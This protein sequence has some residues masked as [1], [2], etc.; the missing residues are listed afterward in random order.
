MT[1]EHT[2]TPTVIAI[3]GPAASGKSTAGYM[4]ARELGFLYL[5]TGSMYRAATLAALIAGIDPGNEAA[6]SA[7]SRDLDLQI[8]PASGAADGRQYTVLLDGDDVTWELRSPDVDAH[9]SV[10]SSFPRVREEMVRRQREIAR[11]GSVVMVG[12]D[13][14]TVVIP[15]APLK[16]YITASPE[17]RARRRWLDRKAQG[18]EADYAEILADINRRDEFDSRRKHSPLRPA[19]D[20][21]IIDNTDLDPEEVLTKIRAFLHA[22]S[23]EEIKEV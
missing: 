16:L 19:E 14:G 12:R 21:V 6:V 20:A 15:D 11:M 10:V 18:H 2:P 5:D 23:S 17:V 7:L 4:L 1:R 3:D 13:I 9:V 22:G 8:K